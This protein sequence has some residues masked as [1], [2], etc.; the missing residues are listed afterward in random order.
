MTSLLFRETE[1]GERRFFTDLD[2]PR[3][4]V[5]LDYSVLLKSFGSVWSGN[6]LGLKQLKSRVF[7]VW[8]LL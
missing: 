5:S 7:L 2:L 6:S 4:R 8:L 1:L 3:G